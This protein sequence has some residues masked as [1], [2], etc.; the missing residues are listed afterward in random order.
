MK[1]SLRLIAESEIWA[2]ELVGVDAQGE[3]I[4]LVRIGER[5]VAY[6]DRCP[7]LGVRLSEGSLAGDVL[8][9][10][11]HQWQY[12][13]ATGRGVNPRD[14]QLERVEVQICDGWVIL[15]MADLDGC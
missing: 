4:L 11:A 9:C 14:V 5:I 15:E 13:I 3:C 6:R 1:R 7:H 12:D 10:R 2:G 8:T